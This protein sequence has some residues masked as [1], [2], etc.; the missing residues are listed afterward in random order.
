MIEKKHSICSVWYYW[1]FLASSG[2][3]GTYYLQV[4]RDYYIGFFSIRIKKK[5]SRNCYSLPFSPPHPPTPMQCEHSN[6]R[7][8]FW[9]MKVWFERIGVSAEF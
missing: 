7:M 9:G 2:G 5:N 4:K 6:L 8:T 1:W 3:L